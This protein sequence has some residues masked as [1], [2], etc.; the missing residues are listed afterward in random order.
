MKQFLFPDK[1]DNEGL[2]R[3]GGKDYHYLV[4][5][6]RLSPGERFPAVLPSGEEVL[7][8]VV[9]T[10]KGEIVCDCGGLDKLDHRLSPRWSSLSRPLPLPEAFPQLYL[11]QALPQGQKMDLIVRQAAECGASGI[12]P[13]LTSRSSK[14]PGSAKVERWERIIREARQQSGSDIATKLFAPCSIEEAIKLCHERSDSISIIFHPLA[15]KYIIDYTI[16]MTNSINIAIGPESGWTEAEFD[17]FCQAGFNPCLLGHTILRT[18][19][20]A[21]FAQATV[22]SVWKKI[23]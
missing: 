20:A 9:S 3:L 13:L 2:I 4:D 10:E 18:E 5:V 15:Q 17:V 6:L 22:L 7:A 16:S 19:T 21:L 12:I 8:E 23:Q 11:L 1:P 14:M